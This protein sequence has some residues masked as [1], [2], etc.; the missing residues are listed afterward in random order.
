MADGIPERVLEHSIILW[1][2]IRILECEIFCRCKAAE[3]KRN[4]DD[5]LTPIAANN[6]IELSEQRSMILFR[7]SKEIDLMN[8]QN[9]ESDVRKTVI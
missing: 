6:V 3:V 1:K 2:W 9:I 7:I 8:I 5:A 4:P